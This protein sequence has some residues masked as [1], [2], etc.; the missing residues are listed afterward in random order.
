MSFSTISIDVIGLSVRSA[1]ALHRIGVHTVND[2]LQY[3]SEQLPQ[4]RNLG[5]K[6]V[7]EILAKIEEYKAILG[8]KKIL[9]GV[10]RTEILQIIEK[11]KKPFYFSDINV[12]SYL[13]A[14]ICYFEN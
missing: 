13:W 9:L 11:F 2:M 12:F 6:S 10:I 8:D 1:N 7:Q 3:D 14:Y 4:V 5:Q